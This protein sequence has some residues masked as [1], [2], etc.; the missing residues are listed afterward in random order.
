MRLEESHHPLAFDVEEFPSKLH[1][2][3][4]T[5]RRAKQIAIDVLDPE[6]AKVAFDV[7]YSIRHG[8]K[9]PICIRCALLDDRGRK[10]AIHGNTQVAAGDPCSMRGSATCLS[11]IVLPMCIAI[12]RKLPMTLRVASKHISTILLPSQSTAQTA[13]TKSL[14]L[15]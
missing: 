7:L 8:Q 6:S 2:M 13:P 14:M 3:C 5:R 12:G 1:S 15:V 11:Q 10:G 4:L 9:S